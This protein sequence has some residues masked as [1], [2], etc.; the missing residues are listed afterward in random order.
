MKI[1][2]QKITFK[3]FFKTLF[4][5]NKYSYLGYIC[6]PYFIYTDRYNRIEE[7]I[8]FVDKIA[9]PKFCPRFVLRLLH[10]YGNDNS[11]ARLR[12]RSL[13]ELRSKLVGG[14]MI[15]DIKTKW[16]DYDI[17]IYGYFPYEIDEEIERIE[18]EFEQL[19]KKLNG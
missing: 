3:L 7:F 14:I 8:E 16:D 12:N 9:K 19:N 6:N 15:T 18:N 5:W 4:P 1:Q 17:R 13:S 11:V 10:L 2:L